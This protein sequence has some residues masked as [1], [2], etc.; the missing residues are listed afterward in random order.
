MNGVFRQ[1]PLRP[2]LLALVA[3]LLLPLVSTAQGT[4]PDISHLPALAGDY[5]RVDSREVGRAY[6]VYV[7][8]PPGYDPKASPRYPVVYVLDGDS[9][10]PLLASSHLFIAMDDGL[11]EA[12]IVGIAY[13]SF[14]PAINRRDVDFTPPSSSG[15][16]APAGGADAFAKFLERELAPRV[17]S[18]YAVDTARRILFGQSRGGTFVLYSALTEP[19]FFWGRIASNPTIPASLDAVGIPSGRTGRP[20]LAL[21]VVMGT[22]DRSTHGSDARAWTRRWQQRSGLP[23]RLETV[24]IKGGTHAANAGDAYRRGLRALFQSGR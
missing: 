7:R 12:V 5:F 2:W 11:P 3:A 13:G 23:W 10:F 19:G 14:D 24:T 20:D 1:R 17:E 9:L 4:T 21:V 18:R 8:L 15:G 22:E 16:T 6:H